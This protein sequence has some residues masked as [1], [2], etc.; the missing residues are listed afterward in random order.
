L[1]DTFGETYEI[2]TEP[3]RQDLVPPCFCV[4]LLSASTTLE[5]NGVKV[6]TGLFDI[7]YHP[8]A[9]MGNMEMYRV[10]NTLTGALEL[11]SVEGVKLRG[12][13][14]RWEV[15][16][17]VLHFFVSYTLRYVVLPD[18]EVMEKLENNTTLKG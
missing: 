10:A 8:A 1:S 3:V 12:V 15:F 5:P 17:E 7:R 14:R 6:L 4:H 18:S 11:I 2:Y 16:D 9:P 13:D